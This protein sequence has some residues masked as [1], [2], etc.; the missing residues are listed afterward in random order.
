MKTEENSRHNHFFATSK[1][2]WQH[3]LLL[4]VY[5]VA[6]GLLLLM[7]VFVV[8]PIVILGQIMNWSARSGQRNARRL[9]GGVGFK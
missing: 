4:P 5:A 6:V 1:L 9:N 8:L 2:W 7:G 3:V